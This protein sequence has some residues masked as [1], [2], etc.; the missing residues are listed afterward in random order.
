MSG[1]KNVSILHLCECL[2]N[3]C[4]CVSSDHVF[5]GRACGIEHLA[6]VSSD[7]PAPPSEPRMSRAQV[8]FLIRLLSPS[9]RYKY[10]ILFNMVPVSARSRLMSIL[11]NYFL[12]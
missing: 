2:R 5:R 4:G 10:R 12:K 11:I 3:E 8:L 1:D 6:R 9:I 7:P